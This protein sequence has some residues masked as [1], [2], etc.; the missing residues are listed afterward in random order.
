M[1]TTDARVDQL[2]FYPVKSLRGLRVEELTM[3]AS[4]PMWDRQWMLVDEKNHF[5]TQ[6]QLPKLA[7]IGVQ[8]F[9]ESA[10]ELSHKDMEG[11]DFGLEEHEG[12]ECQVTIWKKEVPA[13]EVSSEVSEWVSDVAKQKLR[14]VRMSPEAR[15]EFNADVPE[16][17]VRFVDQQPLLVITK[18]A[19]QE[20]EKKAGVTLSMTR[21]RPNIVIDGVPAHAEDAWSGFK[22]GGV[23]FKSIKP[24]SRCKIT[25]VHPLTG[26]V[27]EE[28]LKTLST[29]RRQEKG[30]MFGFYYAHVGDGTISAGSRVHFQI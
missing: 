13:H 9:A 14:L 28:P 5:I 7:T 29:Y 22:V 4:G 15:R 2:Y 6:R 26:E 12:P 25:T 16:R 24:C 20:L 18:A 19:L 10:L 11:I 30:V 17:W 3:N 27:G 1:V 8:M 21:F 23:E